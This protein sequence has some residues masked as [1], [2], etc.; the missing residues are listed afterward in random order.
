MYMLVKEFPMAPATRGGMWGIVAVVLLLVALAILFAA[1][2]LSPRRATFVVSSDGIRIKR[3]LY[4]RA[5]PL[6]S[7]D[8]ERARHI[9]FALEKS[10]EPV[11]RTNGIGL[12]GYSEGWFKLRNGEKALLFVTDRSRVVYVPTDL[13]YSLML[14]VSDPGQFLSALGEV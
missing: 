1:I 10:L 8:V 13:G 6:E 14:S 7:I 12:S 5:I 11:R 4:G 2:A 9:D 3:A